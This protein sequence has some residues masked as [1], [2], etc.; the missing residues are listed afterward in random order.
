M[1]SDSSLYD[2]LH[3]TALAHLRAYES[4]NP[5]FFD[6]IWEH[7]TE[8]AVVYL[9]S[10]NLLPPPF[11]EGLAKDA[12]RNAM[13]FF[14]SVLD[15][16]R[17]EIDNVGVDTS[18]HTVFVRATGHFDLK[19]VPGTHGRDALPFRERLA[20]T[21]HVVFPH[22]PKHQQDQTSGRIYGCGQVDEVRKTKSGANDGQHVSRG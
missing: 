16:T 18:S 7:H 8:D 17:F 13:H 4:P 11:Y 22:G 20:G 15:D 10:N 9:Y 14:G 19:A 12:Y 3:S 1:N 2:T 21:I 6:D 5:W